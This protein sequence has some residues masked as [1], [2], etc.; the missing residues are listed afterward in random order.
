MLLV[1]RFFSDEFESHGQAYKLVF[2]GLV[3]TNAVRFRI[4]ILQAGWI[5]P[6]M[7]RYYF[8]CKLDP[9]LAK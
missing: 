5:H 4:N 2:I 6:R 7:K 8:N 9:S 3:T 1:L